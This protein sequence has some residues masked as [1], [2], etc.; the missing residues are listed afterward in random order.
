MALNDSAVFTAGRGYVYVGPV[1]TA[2]PT[3]EQLRDFDPDTFGA[4][5]HTITGVSEAE[6]NF[7][8]TVE[9]NEESNKTEEISSSASAAEVQSALEQVKGV[10]AGNVVVKG[11]AETGF[12]VY[13]INALQN[14]EVTLSAGD[15]LRSGVK[16]ATGTK[17]TGWE[18]IGHT[19]AEELP[20]FGYE[21][22]DK[23]TKGSWQKQ[24]L[25]E[26]TTEA[27]ADYVTIKVIQFDE[28]T[29]QY[30][31]GKNASK[32][33]GVFAIDS[34]DAEAVEVAILVIIV[35]GK[36][37]IGFSAAKAST[38]RD[39]AI[40]LAND[41]FSMMPIRATFIKHPGR[42]LFEWTTPAPAA[43]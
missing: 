5:S 20:E 41:E 42:H 12:T 25:K 15:V 21:G 18:S 30:Y 13:F 24:A 43:A 16:V 28:K 37:K 27:P 26:V 11:D 22:G 38:R 1:G 39:E 2:A 33:D 23:E 8:L 35:D 7:T 34:G 36:Y 3:R 32:Q 6:E 29:F 10:G 4:G 19:A 31:Y 9:V 17:P 40:S 14:T